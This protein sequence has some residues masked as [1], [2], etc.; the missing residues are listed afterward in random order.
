MSTHSQCLLNR[1][2][3][4][5]TSWIPTKFAVQGRYVKL[6]DDDGEWTDGWRVERV[7]GGA[8]PSEV[9]AKNERNYKSHRKATDV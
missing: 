2:G 3:A 6:K 7:F 9:I 4:Q 8:V 1:L 5:Q